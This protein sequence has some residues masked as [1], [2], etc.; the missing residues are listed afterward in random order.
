MVDEDKLISLA[1]AVTVARQLLG[2]HVARDTMRR[3]LLHGVRGVKL[4][5]QTLGGR[6]HTSV[7]ALIQEP[8]E[9]VSLGG[10]PL[11]SPLEDALDPLP[12]RLEVAQAGPQ[13]RLQIGQRVEQPVVRR[14]T[15]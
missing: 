5:G 9:S 12:H 15:P 8:A 10:L 4:A 3:W 11:G 14:P 13:R 6:H 1:E 7:A 2:R